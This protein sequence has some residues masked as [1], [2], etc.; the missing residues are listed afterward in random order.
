MMPAAVDNNQ[1]W[2]ASGVMLPA[3]GLYDHQSVPAEQMTAA[4]QQLERNLAQM[5]SE[6]AGFGPEHSILQPVALSGNADV[7][8]MG[9]K[10]LNMPESEA[11][12]VA[13][14]DGGGTDVADAS[15]A[16]LVEPSSKKKGGGRKRSKAA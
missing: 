14:A 10:S 15:V 6:E 3:I 8:F 9:G 12:V 2:T 16:D 7:A 4:D 1:Q 5:L 11:K 13:Q